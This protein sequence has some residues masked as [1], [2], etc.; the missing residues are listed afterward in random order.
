MRFSLEFE[1]DESFDGRG[2]V[3]SKGLG[4]RPAAL[5]RSSSN[6]SGEGHNPWQVFAEGLVDVLEAAQASGREP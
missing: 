1:F 3:V 5:E 4:F 2:V 6:E